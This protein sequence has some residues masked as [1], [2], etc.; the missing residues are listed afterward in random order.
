MSVSRSV[1]VYLNEVMCH[2]LQVQLCV[3]ELSRADRVERGWV[4]YK[5]IFEC[6]FEL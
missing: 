5:V 3:S 6:V 1:K 2:V 4:R